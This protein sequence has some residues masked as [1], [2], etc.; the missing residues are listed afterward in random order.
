MILLA[1]AALPPARLVRGKVNDP[2]QHASWWSGDYHSGAV[3]L[4]LSTVLGIGA[5][6]VVSRKHL[7]RRWVFVLIG[8]CV[9]TFPFLFYSVATPA[10][11]AWWVP[12][13][14]MLVTGIFWGT[15]IGLILFYILKREVIAREA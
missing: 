2:L 6:Y 4:S 10:R 13:G 14:E 5:L 8:I 7:Y 9:G 12:F 15:I 1:F 3:V 11:D